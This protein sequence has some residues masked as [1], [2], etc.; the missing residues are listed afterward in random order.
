ML[1]PNWGKE[2]QKR[3]KSAHVIVAGAGGLGCPASLYLAAAGVGKL[4]IIDKEEFE[5]SNLN[6][7]ILG[8]QSDIGC[9]KAEVV[10]DKLVAL[11]PEIKVRPLVL[12]IDEENIGDL[13]Q[14]ADVIVDAMDNW[15]TRFIINKECVKRE[16]PFIHAGIFGLYGQM[17]TILPGK[18]PCLTCLLPKPPKEISKFPVLGVTPA[19]FASLQVLETIK[20]IV[21]FGE[22]LIRK[23]LLFD[24]ETMNFTVIHVER[25]PNCPICAHI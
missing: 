11:N 25:N 6:R 3:L 24:G 22:T 16:I 15:K 18:G 12:E 13:I 17:M 14:D 9:N 7:Q 5:L 10:A 19:V 21:G 1:L 2:G 23:M 20:L 4:T 8:W